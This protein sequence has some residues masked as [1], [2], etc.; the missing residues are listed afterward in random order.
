MFIYTNRAKNATIKTVFPPQEPVDRFMAPAP[1]ACSDHGT[2]PVRP[3]SGLFL[4][5][6]SSATRTCLVWT[7]PAQ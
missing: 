6:Q 7:T 2:A 3:F 4:G 1:C 5:V